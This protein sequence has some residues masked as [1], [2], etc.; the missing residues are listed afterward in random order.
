VPDGLSQRLGFRRT[1][2]RLSGRNL[3]LWSKWPG[4]DPRLN[5]R[6]NVPVGGSA[7]FDSPPVPR[8]FLFTVRMAR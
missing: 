5:W 7:D 4:V 3:Y 2:L 1:S 6:G 8:V